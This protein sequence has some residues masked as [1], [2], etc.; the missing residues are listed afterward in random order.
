ML[1]KLLKLYSCFIDLPKFNNLDLENSLKL[2]N[3]QGTASLG[4]IRA[5]LKTYEIFGFE[6]DTTRVQMSNSIARAYKQVM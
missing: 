3:A 5:A 4:E 1:G 6:F 2:A